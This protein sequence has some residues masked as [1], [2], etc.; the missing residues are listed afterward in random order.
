MWCLNIS[1]PSAAVATDGIFAATLLL[2]L[3]FMLLLQ[4]AGISNPSALPE[5]I[6]GQQAADLES[7]LPRPRPGDF[8]LNGCPCI[9]LDKISG[10]SRSQDFQALPSSYQADFPTAAG[11]GQHMILSRLPGSAC[12]V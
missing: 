12:C 5:A 10:M 11:S 6:T 9:H 2:L 8:E 7:I 1:I 3:V 4:A